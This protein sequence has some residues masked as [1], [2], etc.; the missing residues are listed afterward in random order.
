[1]KIVVTI[2]LVPDTTADKRI[3]PETKRLV[4]TGPV[5]VMNPFDEY[6]LEAA[7]KL[8]DQSGGAATVSVVTLAPESGKEIVRKALALGADDALLIS[9]PAAAGSDVWGTAYAL[10]KA[11]RTKGF[12]LVICGTNSTDASTGELPGA[13]AEYLGVPA[14]TYLRK[15]ALDGTTVRAERETDN[16]FTRLRAPLP[17]L[18]SVTKGIGEP[19]YT[20][21]KGIMNAKKKTI[22]VS[23]LAEAGVDVPIGEAAARTVLTHLETPPVRGKG[24]I[25]EAADALA[26]AAKIVEFLREK[27]LV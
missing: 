3:D 18:A 17:A 14:L 4:R 1:V 6:A 2:K 12:D 25:F 11:I 13:L 22:A 7:L 24:E 21:L 16:G 10:A 9:D 23:T 20:N 26:G 19:R 5:T 15:I 27:K 8:K